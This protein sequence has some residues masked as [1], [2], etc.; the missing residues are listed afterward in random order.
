[1]HLTG[2]EV[3]QGVHDLERCGGLVFEI[4]NRCMTEEHSNI[5]PIEEKSFQERINYALDLHLKEKTTK[6]EASRLANINKRT[7]NR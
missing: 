1:M 5:L 7:L 2:R 4:S 6:I 3:F